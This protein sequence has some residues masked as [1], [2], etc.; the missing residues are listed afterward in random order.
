[1]SLDWSTSLKLSLMLALL[2]SS[3]GASLRGEDIPAPWNVLADGAALLLSGE[4]SWLEPSTPGGPP[5]FLMR[6][7]CWVSVMLAI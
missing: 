4:G 2:L 5:S 3:S 6:T 7:G 1:M